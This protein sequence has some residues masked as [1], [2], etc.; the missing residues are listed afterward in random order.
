M[1]VVLGLGIIF[2]IIAAS[3]VFILQT[4]S[5]IVG[6]LSSLRTARDVVAVL[7]YTGVFDKGS[8]AIENNVTALLPENLKMH[9]TIEE[10]DENMTQQ[11]IIVIFD[12]MNENYFGGKWI[13]ASGNLFRIIRYKVAFE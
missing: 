1:D 10:Y 7:D 3:S 12:D 6:D 4:Q 8:T 11:N 13:S 9:L 2:I 5:S